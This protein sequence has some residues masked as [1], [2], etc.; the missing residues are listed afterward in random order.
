MVEHDNNYVVG[1]GKV[2][3][4]RFLDGSKTKTGERYFG[5]TPGFSLGQE[6]ESLEHF[7]SD[8]GLRVKDASVTLSQDT[9]ATLE[10]DNI[11]TENLALWWL[12]D[13]ANAT[14]VAASDVTE[15]HSVKRGTYIQLGASD[16][17]P[18]GTG[19]VDNVVINSANGV[20]A[21]GALT[22]ADQPAADDTVTI[23]GNVITFKAGGAVGSQV[24]IGAN[25]GATALALA[26]KINATPALPVTAVAAGS[27]VTL[28]AKV[29]GAAGNAVT[30]V[31]GGANT[32]FA[33]A[34]LTGG[35][36]GPITLEGNFE[37]E[38]GTGRVYIEPD[39]PDI[40]D[41]DE[42]TITYDQEAMT[43][44]MVIAK[45]K[46]LYGALRFVAT[47]PVGKKRDAYFPYVKLAPNGEYDLKGEDWQ[48]LSFALDI[49]KLNS[50]TE[51]VYWTTRAG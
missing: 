44:E 21:S 31:E 8:E 20:R 10:C 2:Y 34:T 29:G 19:D 17:M 5:N 51:R 1:K 39:A 46:S 40:G 25:V 13:I 33:N 38:L 15:V 49:L 4:D 41:D 6:E 48:T 47:N 30:T 26:T 12:G 24:N 22:F 36:T 7:N 11:S 14:V 9:S 3:F 32:S 37:V 35:A 27:V 42:L 18:Q 45:G 28:K 50:I 23:G 16:S 43:V